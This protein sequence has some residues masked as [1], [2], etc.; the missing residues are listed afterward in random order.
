MEDIIHVRPDEAADQSL[1]NDLRRSLLPRALHSPYWDGKLCKVIDR[2]RFSDGI[3]LHLEGEDGDVFSVIEDELPSVLFE[4]TPFKE[5]PE[6]REPRSDE[7]A[8]K[9]EIEA[10]AW[11][12]VLDRMIELELTPS[13]VREALN[14]YEDGGDDEPTLVE[15][16]MCTAYVELT[17][18]PRVICV[19][20]E[21]V[22]K[23][24]P[25]QVFLTEIVCQKCGHRF[26]PEQPA[27][28]ECSTVCGYCSQKSKAMTADA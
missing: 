22:A 26:D 23:D 21:A 3:V 18:K 9:E 5:L 25:E 1:T 12:K 15:C 14:K 28:H 17:E 11:R 2:E 19:D 27:E 7:V 6:N 24:K 16:V 20:C 10:A 4:H 8:T 13:V